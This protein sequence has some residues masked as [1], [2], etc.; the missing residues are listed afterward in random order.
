MRARWRRVTLAMSMKQTARQQAGPPCLESGD[1]LIAFRADLG[2]ISWNEA[3]ERLTGLRADEIEG[4]RYWEVVRATDEDGCPFCGPECPIAEAL[5]AGR[6]VESVRVRV[7][8]A[9]TRRPA[10]LSTLTATCGGEDAFFHV[11]QP[12]DARARA[13]GVEPPEETLTPRQTEILRLLAT[14]VGTR[15]IASRLSVSPAT[16]RNHVRTILVRLDCHSRLEAIAVARQR[17]LL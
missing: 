8:A 9:G 15:E 16:V 4:R 7:P 1:A 13:A 14:G 2:V 5:T 11:I 12:L 17:G 6:K 10:R 3:L